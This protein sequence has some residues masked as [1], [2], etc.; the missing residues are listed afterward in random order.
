[1]GAYESLWSQPRMTVK[2]M[3]DLF[4]ANSDALPSDLVEPR[5]ADEMGRR[6]VE[7]IAAA[8]VGRFGVR[9]HRAGE[10]PMKLRDAKHPVEL[11]YYRGFWP[12][13][14]TR[15]V[16]VVGTRKPTDDGIRRARKIAALLV[17]DGFTVVS[18]LAAGI[19]TVAHTTA[20]AAEEGRTIAVVGTP[21]SEVYPG[22][23]RALQERLAEEQLVISQVPVYRSS[24]QDY[25]ANRAFFPERNVTMSAL[26]E[27]TIIIE[28]GDT[29]GTLFQARAALQQHRKLIILDSC[30]Q[31]SDLKWPHQYHERGAIRVRDYE[32]ARE[33]LG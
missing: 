3:A 32:Q 28:A 33:V 30:F 6:V 31:R 19:D 12:L 2:R 20:L 5:A 4:R 26:T 15:C 17:R 22:E 1:M 21:I 11:L 7:M 16:A 27:A 8:G 9:I 24:A 13:V 29:S 10:Y 18:G 23:N 25:R 14:E